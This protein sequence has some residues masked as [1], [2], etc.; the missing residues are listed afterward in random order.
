M[1]KIYESVWRKAE[2]NMMTREKIRL[3]RSGAITH[4]SRSLPN[5]LMK[6]ENGDWRFPSI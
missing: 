1:S 5:I 2:R 6:N 3:I 4:S